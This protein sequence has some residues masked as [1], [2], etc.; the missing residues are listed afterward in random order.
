[1]L[2]GIVTVVVEVLLQPSRF[3]QFEVP[4]KT[5]AWYYQADS[6]ARRISDFGSVEGPLS[7]EFT[8]DV[9]CSRVSDT[10]AL[11]IRALNFPSESLNGQLRGFLVKFLS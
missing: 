6:Q 4:I 11:E 8:G 7:N 9:R 5:V 2:Q 3:L 10:D 1:M